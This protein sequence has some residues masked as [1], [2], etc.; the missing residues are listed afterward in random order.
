MAI[1]WGVDSTTHVDN[2]R[3]VYPPGK[4]FFDLVS[5]QAVANNGTA[6]VFWGR[7]IGSPDTR[8][9]LTQ[10]EINYLA[11][12]GCRI[13][14]I[15]NGHTGL[16]VALQSDGVAA[17]SNARD[18][19][20]AL[21][22]P[23]DGTVW[24]YCDIEST[25]RPTRAFF[26]G[27]FST[28][29]S[30]SGYGPG[31]YGT[32]S[33]T[34]DPEYCYAF[35]NTPTTLRKYLYN[36]QPGG[37]SCGWNNRTFNPASPS[38]CTATADIYQYTLDCPV[39]N[40]SFSPPALRV[41]GDL[42]TADQQSSITPPA[43]PYLQSYPNDIV[44]TFVQFGAGTGTNITP[45]AGWTL[46]LRL[47]D[48]AIE[49]LA[50]FW[51]RANATFGT[52]TFTDPQTG[53]PVLQDITA[54]VYAYKGVDTTN[55][56]DV[57]TVGQANSAAA[58]TTITA[59]SITTLTDNALIVGFFCALEGV[60]SP[61]SPFAMTSINLPL[62]A[63]TIDK[64]YATNGTETLVVGVGDQNV[65][66][67]STGPRTATLN[68]QYT[69]IGII[70]A[71]RP[72]Y[73]EGVD[74][75]LA[76]LTGFNSMWAP[77][78]WQAYV[79]DVHN[80]LNNGGI[81]CAPSLERLPDTRL[82]AVMA[83]AHVGSSPA[84]LG[85][86]VSGNDGQTWAAPVE[87]TNLPFG[88]PQTMVEWN[89]NILV[90]AGANPIS[91]AIFDT[92]ALAWVNFGT[93]QSPLY[94]RSWYAPGG[95][96]IFRFLRAARTFDRTQ[97]AVTAL[98]NGTFSPFI[99]V[100]PDGTAGAAQTIPIFGTA[101]PLM[102]RWVG[103]SPQVARMRP[104]DQL[105]YVSGQL[106][107]DPSVPQYIDLYTRSGGI[108]S[109]NSTY[110]V[111][112]LS[113]LTAPTNPD[114]MQVLR[115]GLWNVD[116]A[117]GPG[118]VAANGLDMYGFFSDNPIRP[119]AGGL[120]GLLSG[121]LRQQVGGVWTETPVN[122]ATNA[123]PPLSEQNY[124]LHSQLM[125]LHDYKFRAVIEMAGPTYPGNGHYWFVRRRLS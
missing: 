47:D 111:D 37:P 48:Y 125:W 3:P 91:Q 21:G 56:I 86:Y 35:T 16:S 22:V 62:T 123:N 10:S 113:K 121:R 72:G 44:L 25:Q 31:V 43:P 61:T 30:T 41:G 78:G 64:F 100:A 13:L 42:A 57:T 122:F 23:E 74:M 116:Y 18:A 83:V 24:I 52:Y 88:L 15:Y 8:F 38:G 107:F 79:I 34:F 33:P 124:N 90:F 11:D 73:R 68:M 95:T 2:V 114:V 69:S 85:A 103:A 118:T 20:R 77:A 71:L 84:D 46:L 93:P 65:G 119:D 49:G 108:W 99:P 5:D 45:P 104:F 97:A 51:A 4:T 92:T 106:Y 29:D 94:W 53:Q 81:V 109:L 110:T 32:T 50:V 6:P 89:G 59:P 7:Y 39:A 19:A 40:A 112:S 26:T 17:A 98:S 80:D 115:R 105:Q 12:K 87:L 55:P 102:L 101:G 117:W 66:P 36:T 75:N 70:V 96:A 27:W 58:S 54:R 63:R 14:L 1:Y 28:I 9:N 67:G 60:S 76:D 82:V 120:S